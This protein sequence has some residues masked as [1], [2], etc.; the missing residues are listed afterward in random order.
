MK[1]KMVVFGLQMAML[2]VVSFVYSLLMGGIFNNPLLVTLII[3]GIGSIDVFC[4]FSLIL[5]LVRKEFVEIYKDSED[6]SVREFFRKPSDT[7]NIIVSAMICGIFGQAVT[8]FPAMVA[9]R[10]LTQ[11]SFGGV[12]ICLVISSVSILTILTILSMSCNSLVVYDTEKLKHELTIKN[13]AELKKYQK[14]L[15]IQLEEFKASNKKKVKKTFELGRQRI[16]DHME[17][18]KIKLTRSILANVAKLPP[19]ERSAA[20]RRAQEMIQLFET[21]CRKQLDDFDLL[22]PK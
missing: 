6:V 20:G 14:Q 1:K 19:E 7:I 4:G 16:V 15:D 18:E 11:E 12:V 5:Y 3:A 22:H 21:A 17:D 9:D 2:A 13:D 8:F 10:I